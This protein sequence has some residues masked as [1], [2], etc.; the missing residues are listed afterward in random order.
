LSIAQS[1][2]ALANSVAGGGSPP[3]HRAH[4]QTR[5]DGLGDDGQEGALSGTD[6][7]GG[8]NEITPNISGVTKRLKQHAMQC[9][10]IRRSGLKK[11]CAHAKLTASL[12]RIQTMIGL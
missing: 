9:R 11:L 2:S 8:L 7:V 1:A 6:R 12:T 4:Q 5:Q 10:S 3:S